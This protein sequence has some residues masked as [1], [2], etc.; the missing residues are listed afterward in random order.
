MLHDVNRKKRERELRNAGNLYKLEKARTLILSGASKRNAVE[1]L[2]LA[3]VKL[4]S[5]F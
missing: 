2:I 1:K 5:V 3:S 4:M